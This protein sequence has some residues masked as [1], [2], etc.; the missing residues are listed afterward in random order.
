MELLLVTGLFAAAQN[1]YLTANCMMRGSPDEVMRPN[2]ALENVVF[3]LSGRNQL[4]ALNAS[5]RASTRWRVP[6]RNDRTSDRSTTLRPGPS[7]ALRTELPY[8]PSAGCW[9]ARG[10]S[11]L[12]IVPSPYG[13][14]SV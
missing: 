13:L 14:S 5:T 8:V 9:N 2:V 11:Q 12:L 10:L 6:S 4:N 1:S 7:Y 3:G